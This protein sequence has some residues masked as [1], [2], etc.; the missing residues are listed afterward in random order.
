[1]HV[2]LGEILVC[3][4]L[5]TAQQVTEVLERQQST[6]TPF[7]ALAER[8]FG[9]APDAIEDA[10][11]AQ[12]A[13]LTQTIDPRSEPLCT[14][15]LKLITRR[16]AWQFCVIPVRQDDAEVMI[17]TTQQHLRRALRFATR[18]LGVPSYFVMAENEAMGEALCRLYPMDG[19]T[20]ASVH[21]DA[22][23]HLVAQVSEG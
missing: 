15:A 10:W 4:G 6:G 16:Q 20:P 13:R 19:M 23:Q 18:V 9:V 11:A 3:R 12:Y 14:E 22:M 17:A 21:L 1:M 7:G 8:M 2:R 5:L